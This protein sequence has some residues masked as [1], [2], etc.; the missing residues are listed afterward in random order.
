MEFQIQD[1]SDHNLIYLQTSDH[2]PIN[3]E[4]LAGLFYFFWITRSPRN[5]IIKTKLDVE[6]DHHPFLNVLNIFVDAQSKHE[7]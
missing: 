4:T 2:P 5:R 3:T 1:T 6:F 7:T